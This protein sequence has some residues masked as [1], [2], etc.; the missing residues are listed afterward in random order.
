MQINQERVDELQTLVMTLTDPEANTRLE[1]A[2]LK[3]LFEQNRDRALSI[4]PHEVFELF[5]RLLVSGRPADSLL[6]S[7]DKVFNVFYKGLSAY[8]W[9]RPR[10]GGFLDILS[11]ENKAMLAK[12]EEIRKMLQSGLDKDQRT[13]LAGLFRDLEP[14]KDH[15]LKKENILF[16]YLEKKHPRFDG[17][18]IM[19]ALHDQARASL[20]QV[21]HL[22]E[23]SDEEMEIK[24]AIG[25]LFFSMHGLVIKEDLILFPAAADVIEAH[26]WADMERQSMEYG[27]PFIDRPEWSNHEKQADQKTIG[28]KPTGALSFKTETGTISLSQVEMI[29]NAL[30]VDLS[31]VDEDDKLRFFTR[32]KDRIFP[33]SPAAIG[34]DVRN[35]HPP[36]SVGVVLEIIEAFR[37][38]RRD[39]AS[40]WIER[41]NRMILI[42]YFALRDESGQYRGTLEVSQDVTEARSLEGE[43]RLLQWDA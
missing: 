28:Q 18:A 7:L 39:Q 22:L 40:F 31:F 32:P 15:Y 26:E 17:L 43:R 16:P 25:D 41:K 4:T 27:F 29:F 30:P 35:C 11:L 1:P 34:R 13:V 37:S 14:F 24:M 19:W 38:G 8:T 21:I 12:L 10:A 23:S 2:A 9:T 20:K 3:A 6:K 5:H 42:Q 36:A 33:R